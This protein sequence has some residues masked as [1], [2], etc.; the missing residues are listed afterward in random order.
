MHAIS[1]VIIA[2]LTTG[3]KKDNSDAET[4]T[5]CRSISKKKIVFSILKNNKF[6]RLS[7]ILF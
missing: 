5:G 7:Y 1:L 2:L 4:R 3:S 6:V